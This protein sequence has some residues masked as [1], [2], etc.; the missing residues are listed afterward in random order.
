MGGFIRYLIE[1]MAKE[2]ID[3]TCAVIVNI[4]KYVPGV[5]RVDEEVSIKPRHLTFFFLAVLRQ[6]RCM[7]KQCV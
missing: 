3:L 2:A 6:K 1:G 7:R 5:Q 4:L